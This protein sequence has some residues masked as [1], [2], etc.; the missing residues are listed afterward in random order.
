MEGKMSFA[1]CP[2]RPLG[3]SRHPSIGGKR[4][5]LLFVDSYTRMMR[6]YFL[7]QKS[8]AFSY[9]LLFKAFTEKQS[10]HNLKILRTNH[11]REFNW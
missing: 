1:T 10:G 3:P 7:E 11:G 2:C 9:F 5:F 8:Q 6:V 4:Y